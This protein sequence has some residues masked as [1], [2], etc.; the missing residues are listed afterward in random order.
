M[1]KPIKRKISRQGTGAEET[2]R[3][4]MSVAVEKIE[5]NLRQVIIGAAVV[6]AVIIVVGG[7][8]FFRSS[9]EKKA[10]RLFYE[11]YKAYHGLYDAQALTPSERYE[12]SLESFKKSYEAKHAPQ[13]LLYIAN[14]QDQMG[15]YDEAIQSLKDLE[16]NYPDN[17][18]FVPLAI[19][20]S[21]VIQLKAGR[22]DEALGTLDRLYSSGFATYRDVAL[23][24][25]AR[26]LDGMGK[27][28]EA[29]KKYQKLLTEFPESPFAEEARMKVGEEDKEAGVEAP[30]KAE[31]PGK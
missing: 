2:V 7:L 30:E 6:L 10:D 26:V 12:R 15:K 24:E 31:A 11:G 4:F 27:Q 17:S 5:N 20:K 23:A 9:S 21:A 8:F 19:Y 29:L 25:S 14:S 22:T 13:T 3:T 16:K 28:D 1:P 18:V